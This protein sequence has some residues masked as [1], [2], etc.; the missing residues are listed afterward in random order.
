MSPALASAVTV[1]TPP[2]EAVAVSS[3]VW[4]PHPEEQ[5]PFTSP[6]DAVADEVSVGLES[7]AVAL[8]PVVW[9]PHPTSQPPL[10]SPAEAEVVP[11]PTPVAVA[12]SFSVLEPQPP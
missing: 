3:V 11:R 5:P 1:P 6:A 10:M 4:A 9:A 2:A 12:E 8:S 7:V